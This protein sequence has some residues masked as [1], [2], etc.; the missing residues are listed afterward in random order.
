MSH[1]MKVALVVVLLVVPTSANA[2]IMEWRYTGTIASGV[3]GLSPLHPGYALTPDFQIGSPVDLRL[4]ANSSAPDQC[5]AAGAAYYWGLSGSLS[6]GEVAYSAGGAVEIGPFNLA[7]NNCVSDARPLDLRMFGGA[8]TT[9]PGALFPGL[10]WGFDGSGTG[11]SVNFPTRAP[12]PGSPL[13]LFIHGGIF[14][15]PYAWEYIEVDFTSVT[16]TLLVPAPP[17][18]TVTLL[19]VVWALARRRRR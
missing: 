2:A 16:T 12:S 11:G 14:A 8:F 1:L 13:Y 18:T 15:P 10:G 4:I 9:A 6:V 17:I 5:E 3:L 19:G 7:G